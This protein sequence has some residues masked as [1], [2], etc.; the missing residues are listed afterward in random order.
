MG[1]SHS[2]TA[3]VRAQARGS[4]PSHGSR[5]FYLRQCY[6]RVVIRLAGR[7]IN[8]L[9]RQQAVT[10]RPVDLEIPW[11]D[12]VKLRPSCVASAAGSKPN[13]IAILDAEVPGVF[14]RN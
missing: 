3:P 2:R 6:E 1:V 10:F 11:F 13:R 8:R 12:P 7:N 9:A 4:R 5:F 14:R